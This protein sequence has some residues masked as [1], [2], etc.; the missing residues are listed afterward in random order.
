MLKLKNCLAIFVRLAIYFDSLR[1][2]ELSCQ[3][4]KFSC[5]F[6][7]E[8]AKF[9]RKNGVGKHNDMVRIYCNSSPFYSFH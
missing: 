1:V 7:S 4:K 6:G 2:H 9:A 5:V 8:K 3:L